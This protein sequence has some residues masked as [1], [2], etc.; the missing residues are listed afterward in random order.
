MQN[1]FFSAAI[2]DIHAFFK[3][4]VPKWKER[5]KLMIAG[6]VTLPCFIISVPEAKQVMKRISVDKKTEN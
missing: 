4:S 3:C 6:E 1:N 5:N 2:M